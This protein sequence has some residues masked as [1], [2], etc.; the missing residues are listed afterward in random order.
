M[1]DLL[2][3]FERFRSQ[4]ENLLGC[5]AQLRIVG[6][7]PGNQFTFPL[8]AFGML[9]AGVRL[10]KKAGQASELGV[11]LLV[12]SD[13]VFFRRMQD[14]ILLSCKYTC[15]RL[16]DNKK[17]PARTAFHKKANGYRKSS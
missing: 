16:F 7:K 12:A 11:L 4:L 1:P 14:S 13:E 15:S 6:R 8:L 5:R 9:P 3:R 2:Q 10:T 17:L